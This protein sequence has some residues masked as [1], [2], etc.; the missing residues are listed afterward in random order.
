VRVAESVRHTG[1]VS[2]KVLPLQAERTA[3]GVRVTVPSGGFI[4]EIGGFEREVRLT[5]PPGA[6]VE[7]ATTSR[8]DAAGPRSSLRVRAADG[9]IHVRDHRGALDLQTDCGRIEL[10]DA[11]GPRV[12]AQSRNGSLTLTRVLAEQL[13][14]RTDDGRISADAVRLVDGALTTRDGRVRV[15]YTPDSEATVSIHT[16]DGRITAPQATTISTDG[17]EDRHS[18]TVRLGSGRG[19]FEVSSGNG[20]IS[21]TQG[22]Q[23]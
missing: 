22:A 7:V 3:N 18:R 19:R 14:A 2:R 8:V 1:W 11:Q 4:F 13:E 16:G 6:N 5:V 9:S 15:G 17:E 12:L 10:I 23:V 21:V 20:S